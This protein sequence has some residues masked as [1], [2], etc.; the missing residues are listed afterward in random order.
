MSTGVLLSLST[1]EQAF[2]SEAE[3][4]NDRSSS[5]VNDVM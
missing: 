3:E 5:L 2:F 4:I 1:D